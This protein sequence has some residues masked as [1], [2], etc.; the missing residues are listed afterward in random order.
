MKLKQA[1][2]E[3]SF[4]ADRG[5]YPINLCLVVSAAGL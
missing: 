3:E 1:V 2:R 5:D 4:R